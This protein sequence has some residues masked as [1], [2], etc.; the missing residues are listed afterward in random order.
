LQLKI[1]F[2]IGTVKS[3]T[4]L[5]SLV[6]GI[7]V[8]TWDFSD[9]SK[10]NIPSLLSSEVTLFYS[11]LDLNV[12]QVVVKPAYQARKLGANHPPLDTHLRDKTVSYFPFLNIPISGSNF[13]VFDT[14]I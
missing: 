10:T 13:F 8:T 1:Y 4:S 2:L 5:T 11:I 9:E 6:S 7:V 12:F 14:Y 3:G